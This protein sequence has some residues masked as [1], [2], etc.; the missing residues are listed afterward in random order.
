MEVLSQTFNVC[1]AG[2]KGVWEDDG[3]NVGAG[4]VGNDEMFPYVSFTLE[5]NEE[6]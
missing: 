4:L 6:A 5:L 1:T 3:N 2:R